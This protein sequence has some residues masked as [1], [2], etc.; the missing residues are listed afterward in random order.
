MIFEFIQIYK[1]RKYI[2]IKIILHD[3]L[4]IEKIKHG[5]NQEDI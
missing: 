5:F 2:T 1:H 4:I 3:Q